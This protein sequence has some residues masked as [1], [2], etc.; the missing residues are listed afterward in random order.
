[1]YVFKYRLIKRRHTNGIIHID[2]ILDSD[3]RPLILFRVRS[4]K[5][6]TL[7]QPASL[8]VRIF[9]CVSVAFNHSITSRGTVSVALIEATSRLTSV[10]AMLKNTIQLCALEH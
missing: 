5:F 10:S 1:M 9:M 8:F 7:F 3:L 4:M 6:K 2:F